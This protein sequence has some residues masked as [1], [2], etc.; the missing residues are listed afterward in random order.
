MSNI[1]SFQDLQTLKTIDLQINGSMIQAEVIQQGEDEAMVEPLS[2]TVSEP[3]QEEP[4]QG[5]TEE[6]T[7]IVTELPETTTVPPH[8][9]PQVFA[10]IIEEEIIEE[11]TVEVKL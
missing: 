9:R 4:V 6:E 7:D 3:V 11:E 10:E 5:E 1:F 8:P 2:V